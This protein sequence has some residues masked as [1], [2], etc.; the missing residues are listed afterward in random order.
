MISVSHP[1]HLQRS[2]NLSLG[3]LRKHHRLQY[4]IPFH[5]HLCLGE[6]FKLNRSRMCELLGYRKSDCTEPHLT[7]GWD[8][9]PPF[10]KLVIFQEKGAAIAGQP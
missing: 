1:K 8:S 4:I 9:S 3:P 10:R 5:W 6:S 7:S 2:T